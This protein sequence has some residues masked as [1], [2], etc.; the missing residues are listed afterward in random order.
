[1]RPQQHSGRARK[2]RLLATKFQRVRN[3]HPARNQELVRLHYR[4]LPVERAVYLLHRR[5][6]LP[7]RCAEAAPR[8]CVRYRSASGARQD[9]EDGGGRGTESKT[10]LAQ[11]AGRFDPRR[12]SPPRDVILR[13]EGTTVPFQG[14]FSC[15]D[16]VSDKPQVSGRV[17]I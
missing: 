3:H 4:L 13:R 1:L 16:L 2:E 6:A 11:N 9:E 15:D 5:S 17:Y 14:V 10:S 8:R 7:S 12:V